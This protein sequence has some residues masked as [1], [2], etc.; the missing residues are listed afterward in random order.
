M[1][2]LPYQADPYPVNFLYVP[3]RSQN[4]IALMKD[5]TFFK[6]GTTSHILLYFWTH[7]SNYC[8]YSIPTKN[9]PLSNWTGTQR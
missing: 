5:L 4:I 2:K 9:N 3:E 6:K 7:V 1:N 8:C